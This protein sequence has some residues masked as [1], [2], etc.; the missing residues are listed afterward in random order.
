[1][2]AGNG[3]VVNRNAA[4]PDNNSSFTWRKGEKKHTHTY[5]PLPLETVSVH[6]R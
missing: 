2:A 5:G 6:P 1:M 3:G 4:G